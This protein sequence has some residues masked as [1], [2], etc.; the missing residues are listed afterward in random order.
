MHYCTRFFR[1][2]VVNPDLQGNHTHYRLYVIEILFTLPTN[3]YEY[4]NILR[5]LS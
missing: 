3:N 1:D 5:L 4:T 2:E